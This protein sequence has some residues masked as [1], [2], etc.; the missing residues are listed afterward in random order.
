MR[1]GYSIN[2][3]FYPPIIANGQNP[4]ATMQTSLQYAAAYYP[5]YRYSMNAKQ[6]T[7]MQQTNGCFSLN[8]YTPLWYPNADYTVQIG[9]SQLW[10]PA[11][12]IYGYIN[13]VPVK[14]VGSVYDDWYIQ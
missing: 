8:H 11:G 2:L 4:P 14:I 12:M 3:A 1:S 7:T 9:V 6:Y 10:T 5:E 13:C